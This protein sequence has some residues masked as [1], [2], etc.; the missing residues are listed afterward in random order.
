MFRQNHCHSVALLVRPSEPKERVELTA[1]AARLASA[2]ASAAR[3]SVPV[4]AAIWIAC[5]VLQVAPV[6]SADFCRELTVRTAPA[7]RGSTLQRWVLQ[8]R[9]GAAFTDDTLPYVWT[10]TR[11]HLGEQPD[12]VEA[13]LALAAE[14]ADLRAV[15]DAECA[16]A[17]A[18]LTVS[19]AAALSW[20]AGTADATSLNL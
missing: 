8:L 11:L 19:E 7:A 16:A 18:G 14:P 2:A 4:D 20:P 17:A 3:C 9:G 10:P 15:L 13:A 5:E 1:F 12:I 6:A